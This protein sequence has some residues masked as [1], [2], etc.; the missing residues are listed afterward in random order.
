MGKKVIILNGS[1]REKGNTDLLIEAFMNGA[2]SSG[3][4]VHRFDLRNLNINHCKGCQ[5]GGK[6]RDLPCTQHD[7]MDKIYPAFQAA[8]VLV[9]ASPLYCWGWTAYLKNAFDRCYAV[10]EANS[11]N[12]DYNTP[13][14]DCVMLIAAEGDYPENFSLV[15]NY[16]EGILQHLKWNDLG[17]I[18]AGGVFNIG[19]IKDKPSLEEARK[20][21]ASL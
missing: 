15:V 10:T 18:L 9:F 5:T 3:H 19:D 1:P 2:A 6:E 13:H 11:S 20:L 16:Y 21:G 17:K 8:D 14:K 4:E 12:G 7:D